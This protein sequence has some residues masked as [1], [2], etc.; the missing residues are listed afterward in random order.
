MFRRSLIRISIASQELIKAFSFLTELHTVQNVGQIDNEA[1]KNLG[2]EHSDCWYLECF[3]ALIF[4]FRKC[5]EKFST[6]LKSWYFIKCPTMNILAQN[7]QISFKIKAFLKNLM[8]IF[9]FILIY[10]YECFADVYI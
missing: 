10:M 6:T 3:C 9:R 2:K 5:E 4:F 1:I 8:K 7:I